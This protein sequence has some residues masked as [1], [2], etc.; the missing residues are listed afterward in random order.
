MCAETQTLP[1]NLGELFESLPPY[2]DPYTVEK[3]EVRHRRVFRGGYYIVKFEDKTFKLTDYQ[4][5]VLKTIRDAEK[6]IRSFGGR[7]ALTEAAGYSF[8][9]VS[10][11][12]KKIDELVEMGLIE[13]FKLPDRNYSIW[14]LTEWG[15]AVLN[16]IEEYEK[17]R[18]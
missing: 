8:N 9:Y 17:N 11:Y 10:Y 4:V 14:V 16:A 6:E 5:H 12:E 3:F 13:R 15:E 18:A 7:W 2:P 1:F